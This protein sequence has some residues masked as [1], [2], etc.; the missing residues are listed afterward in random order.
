MSKDFEP[1]N[2]S[3]YFRSFG[4]FTSNLAGLQYENNVHNRLFS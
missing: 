3:H 4:V 2:R 1:D